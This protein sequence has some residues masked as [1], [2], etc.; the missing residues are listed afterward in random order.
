MPL[1]VDH[2]IFVEWLTEIAKHCDIIFRFSIIFRC[3]IRFYALFNNFSQL[4]VSFELCRLYLHLCKHV[5][6]FRLIVA[7]I[8]KIWNHAFIRIQSGWWLF[9]HLK[10]IEQK[11]FVSAIISLNSLLYIKKLKVKFFYEKWSIHCNYKSFIRNSI[12]FCDKNYRNFI[13][14]VSKFNFMLHETKHLKELYWN[15]IQWNSTVQI[16]FMYAIHEYIKRTRLWSIFINIITFCLIF[17]AEN[18]F[19]RWR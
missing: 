7:K 13:C 14:S 10:W 9:D 8:L 17:N 3:A 6:N 1:N 5:N 16:L 15:C 11:K 4:S 12:G 18:K 2:S 19:I